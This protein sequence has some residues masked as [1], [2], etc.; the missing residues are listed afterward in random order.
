MLTSLLKALMCVKCLLTL[1]RCIAFLSSF[2]WCRFVNVHCPSK[3]RV[4]N[5]FWTKSLKINIDKYFKGK[6]L[7]LL[8]NN[9]LTQMF[10]RSFIFRFVYVPW[11]WLSNWSLNFSFW[12]FEF[13]N[14][15]KYH[16]FNVPFEVPL[17]IALRVLWKCILTYP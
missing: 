5:Q 11:K 14:A 10:R 4:S 1:C 12:E 17:L 3:H 16:M 7:S 9:L 13:M 2:C 6:C 15:L 8:E